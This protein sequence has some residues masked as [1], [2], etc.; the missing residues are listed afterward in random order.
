MSLN[1]NV[2]RC[3]IFALGGKMFQF[4]ANGGDWKDVTVTVRA[5]YSGARLR[6]TATVHF[7]VVIHGGGEPWEPYDWEISDFAGR[8]RVWND[9]GALI[10]KLRA[11]LAH[12]GGEITVRILF[13]NI[14]VPAIGDVAEV[15]RKRD[16][17]LRKIQNQAQLAMSRAGA[18]MTLMEGMQPWSVVE[19]ARY[20]DLLMIAKSAGEDDTEA[21]RQLAKLPIVSLRPDY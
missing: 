19:Q 4:L 14:R 6:C 8:V 10:A 13:E 17:T 15:A 21:Y 12:P 11:A 9:L 18:Y 3:T 5:Q 2:L 20:D 7:P 16:V 1:L